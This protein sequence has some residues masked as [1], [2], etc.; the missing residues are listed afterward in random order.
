MVGI[1]PKN[2]SHQVLRTIEVDSDSERL[3]A[4][5]T[6]VRYDFRSLLNTN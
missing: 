2:E 6:T 1:S 3:H 4:N 5:V